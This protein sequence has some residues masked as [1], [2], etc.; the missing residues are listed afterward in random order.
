LLAGATYADSAAGSCGFGGTCEVVVTDSDNA[1]VTVKSAVHFGV[2]T[3]SLAKVTA[4]PANYPDVVTTAGLP[5]G[6][7]VTVEECDAAVSVPATVATNCDASTAIT[8]TVG[9]NGKVLFS[10]A[11]V[12][13]L[14]G[15]RYADTAAGMCAYG[16]AC[17]AVLTDANNAAVALGRTIHFAVPKAKVMQTTGVVAGSSD[18]VTATAFPVGDDV[19]AVECDTS[20]SVPGS[21]TTDCDASTEITGV[22]GATGSVAFS[23]AGVTVLAGGAYSET[24]SGSVSAGGK[25]D[26][27]VEDASDPATF[28]VVKITLAT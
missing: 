12:T 26:I 18:S 17:K 19:V 15:D 23:P 14:A 25:A 22:A 11:A 24:G 5:I 9:A 1:A 6:D 16:G 10:P 2:L 7:A 20:V 21:L 27:V 4:V 3:F 8:G 28:V 13:L